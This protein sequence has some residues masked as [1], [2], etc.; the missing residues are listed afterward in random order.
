MGLIA[1]SLVW[2]CNMSLSNT[3]LILIIALLCYLLT[4][5][6]AAGLQVNLGSH[7]N[8]KT[9]S[10]GLNDT[11]A[12]FDGFGRALPVE[13]LPKATSFVYQGVEVCICLL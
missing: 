6:E 8:A 12:D 10:T 7:L 9:A 5:T 2:L 13:H 11:L 4:L 3:S 1:S